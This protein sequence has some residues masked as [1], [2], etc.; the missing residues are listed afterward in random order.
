MKKIK[1]EKIVKRHLK[2]EE[3]S[4]LFKSEKRIKM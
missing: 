2:K 3:R 4:I 1:I